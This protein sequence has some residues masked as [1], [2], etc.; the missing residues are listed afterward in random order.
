MELVIGIVVLIMAVVTI[1]VAVGPGPLRTFLGKFIPCLDPRGFACQIYE[2]EDPELVL[3]FQISGRILSPKTGLTTLI[4][5][6]LQDV[7][8]P[9]DPKPIL[10]RNK[11]LQQENSLEF[12]YTMDNGP[13]PSRNSVLKDWVDFFE[14]PCRELVF[15]RQGY[16]TLE[17]S[18]HVISL[19][20]QKVLA[21]AKSEILTITEQPGYEA[22]QQNQYTRRKSVIQLAAAIWNLIGRPEALRDEIEQKL[23]RKYSGASANVSE[24]PEEILDASAGKSP[25]FMII[26]ACESIQEV[27]GQAECIDILVLCLEIAAGA[28]AITEEVSRALGMICERLGVSSERYHQLSQKILSGH[29][30]KVANPRQLLGIT[31]SM[32][33][34]QVLQ[35][36]TK[37]YRKWNSRVTHSDESVRQQADR[38]L[39]LI[40]E[41]R[42]EYQHCV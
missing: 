41:L 36:L 19:T 28:E 16:R 22:I 24:S 26:E 34:D 12:I 17:A 23:N 38:M 14:I 13:L 40:M 18:V 35:Q 1:A 32:S 25:N 9:G 37:E 5:L 2:T 15:P 21:S 33:D 31:D 3:H 42:N 6:Q 10:T 11:T 20:D 7:T 8:S 29:S 30:E 4:S 39:N 27:A